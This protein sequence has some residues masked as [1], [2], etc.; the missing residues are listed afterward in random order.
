MSGRS[1]ATASI[2]YL[3]HD[4]NDPAVERRTA[5]L[6]A[7]GARVRLAGFS[8]GAGRSSREG[9][10]VDLGRT[11]DA[12]LGHRAALVALR[13]ADAGR[14]AARVADLRPDILIAR[15]LEMLVL[16][17]RVRAALPHAPPVVYECLDI[18]RLMLG[19]GPVSR[20]LRAVEARGMAASCGLLVS[21]PAFLSQYFRLQ[22]ERALAGL[23]TMLVENRPLE[24]KAPAAAAGRASERPGPTEDAVRRP[25][26]IGWFGAL[27]CRRSLDLLS[28][29]AAAQGGRFEV[30]LRGR[31][32]LA[33]IPDFHDRVR[34]AP[35]LSY[36]GPY[37]AADLP[38]VYG[39]VDLAWAIDFYEAGAN[40]AWLLPNR[41]YECC[42]H[43]AVPIALAGTQTAATMRG[44][45]VGIVIADGST[46]ALDEA[47]GGLDRS[48][49][50]GLGL[51]V[52]A[53]DRSLW[54]AGQGACDALVETLL[55][56][57]SRSV[58]DRPSERL[59]VA[60]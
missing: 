7:G 4:L 38:V 31:P 42:A 14:V 53:S 1:G 28:A 13:C 36:L 58:S 50:A 25:I 15:N 10:A 33:A 49:V 51:A 26:R 45:G 43:G 56:M 54:V 47:L 5:M 6:E 32:A 55:A 44:R 2:L 41:L 22:Q 35:H 34:R 29:F 57:A 17:H 46:G 37:A 23:A 8:R 27:R 16:A 9:R 19:G 39:E 20:T 60:A 59:A 30:V 48:L 24:R 11:H 40:S 52:R 12:R 21:S 18:H 3:V